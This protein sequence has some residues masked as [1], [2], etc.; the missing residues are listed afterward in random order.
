MGEWRD[1]VRLKR[2]YLG[3][4]IAV[5][6]I[7]RG[8]MNRRLLPVLIGLS[9]LFLPDFCL[10]SQ[11][12]ESQRLDRIDAFL[13]QYCLDCHDEV[14][15]KANLDLASLD[16]GQANYHTWSTTFDRVDDVEMPPVDKQQPSVEQRD[17]FLADIAAALAELEVAQRK[18]NGR[19]TVRRLNRSEYEHSLQDLLALPY[20]SIRESLPPEGTAGGFDKSA[21]ALDFSHVHASRLSEVADAA[22]RKAISPRRQKPRSRTIRFEVNRNTLKSGLNGFH[23]LLKQS[24]SIPMVGMKIDETVDRYRGNF[25]ARDPGRFVDRPPFFDG[26]TIF[27]NGEFNLGMKIRSFDIPVAGYY[28]IRVHG[29]AILNDHGK[30]IPTQKTGTV[31]FYSNDR[32]LGFVDLPAYNPTTAELKVW[33]EPED[34]IKPLAASAPFAKVAVLTRS[35][36]GV[37]MPRE[38]EAFRKFKAAGINFQ[39]FELEGPLYQDWPPKSHQQLFS[40]LPVREKT[41]KAQGRS[42]QV[43]IV[44]VVT[45]RPKADARKLLK[46]FLERALRKPVNPSDL[47]TPLAIINEKLNR[48]EPFMEAMISGYRAVLTSPDFLLMNSQPGKLSDSALAERLAFFLW[49]SVPDEILRDLAQTGKLSEP[50]V[51]HQQVERLLNHQKSDRFVS[52]F[53][54]KWLKLEDIA[55]TEPDANLYPDYTPLLMD[56]ALWESNH[57]FRELIEQDLGA[58]H[59][60]YSDFAMINQRL[61]ELYRLP[62][63]YGNEIRRVQL[64]KNS[65][66]GGF[67]TQAAVL[68]T[69]ANGTVTSPVVRGDYVQTHFLGDPPPPPPPIVPAVEPDITGVT[70]IRE[71]LSKHREAKEC[72]SCHKKIDPPGFALEQFDVMGGFRQ[73]YRSLKNGRLIKDLYLDGKEA[74]TFSALPVDASGQMRSGEEFRGINDFKGILL[75]RR[76]Q[77]AENLLEHIIVYATGASVGYSDREVVEALLIDLESSDYGVRS[78]IHAV[79]QSP[80]FLEK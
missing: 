27:N 78:M 13:S 28:I 37:P 65:V 32:T 52:H 72:A 8:G 6:N 10:S 55:L 20:L 63:V 25:E 80:L 67:L 68:K 33:L 1:S 7:V 18:N 69:T 23:A 2:E 40:S 76:K 60:V 21:E 58:A 35:K 4:K 19:A 22:L 43:S 61:A 34:T 44:D 75:K 31:G 49:N 56:S 17:Q 42:E 70:T 15:A 36:R 74:R 46:S 47:Q 24:K 9:T 66:R 14:T 39:W 16:F 26:L 38:N 71:Q 5:R 12:A 50:K 73:N 57:F 29:F 59:V 64:P 3:N 53:L 11:E 79:V 30:L 51:L 62:G 41:E 45:Q 48:D 54:D 77:I